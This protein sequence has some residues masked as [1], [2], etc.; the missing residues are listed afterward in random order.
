MVKLLNTAYVSVDR[1]HHE[2]VRAIVGNGGIITYNCWVSQ[3]DDL[4]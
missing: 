4:Y 2:V 3:T 1:A